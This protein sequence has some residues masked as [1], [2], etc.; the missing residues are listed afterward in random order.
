[1]ASSS[2]MGDNCHPSI[3]GPFKKNITEGNIAPNERIIQ[4]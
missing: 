3:S 1:M 4:I 2:T